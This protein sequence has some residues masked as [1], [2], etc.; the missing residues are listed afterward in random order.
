MRDHSR[1]C[2]R[3]AGVPSVNI[4][5]LESLNRRQSGATRT[6]GQAD[7]PQVFIGQVRQL[8]ERDLVRGKRILVFRK[9]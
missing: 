8:I 6:D 4:V 2:C 1:A 7:F 3:L 5:G 9:A